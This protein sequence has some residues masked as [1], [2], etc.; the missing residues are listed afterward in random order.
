MSEQA[1]FNLEIVVWKDHSEE[2]TLEPKTKEP[3]MQREGRISQVEET[4]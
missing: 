4:A 2:V 3:G 1:E